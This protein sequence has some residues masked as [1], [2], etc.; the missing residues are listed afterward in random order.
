M[1]WSGMHNREQNVASFPTHRRNTFAGI[2]NRLG[3]LMNRVVPCGDAMKGAG[4]PHPFGEPG[5]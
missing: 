1:T 4:P 2:G 3:G 5:D